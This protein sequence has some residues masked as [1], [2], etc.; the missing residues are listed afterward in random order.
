MDNEQGKIL[1]ID[2]DPLQRS[3]TSLMLKKLEYRVLTAS[4][5]MEVP[6]KQKKIRYFDDE[7]I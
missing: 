3:I 4:T 6:V 5:D 7:S 1:F 2:D